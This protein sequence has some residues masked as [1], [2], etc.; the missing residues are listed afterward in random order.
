M[1]LWLLRN[2]ELQ[3]MTSAQ[4]ALLHD[5]CYLVGMTGP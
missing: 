3:R 1:G 5:V 4:Q 2:L